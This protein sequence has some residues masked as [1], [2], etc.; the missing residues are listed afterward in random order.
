MF[1]SLTERFIK[2]PL[3]FLQKR[4]ICPPDEISGDTTRGTNVTRLDTS[5][6][7]PAH[8]DYN[9]QPQSVR[10]AYIRNAMKVAYIKMYKDERNDPKIRNDEGADTVRFKSSFKAKSGHKPV[11]FLPWDAGGAI[12]KLQIPQKGAMN[13]DPDIFFTAAINGCSIFVQGNAD[14]PSVYH[15]GGSTGQSDPSEGARFWRNALD[16]HIQNTATALARGPI[17]GEVS[18][19]DY[20]K[21]PGVA[22]GTTNRALQFE[23]HLQNNLNKHG[24]FTVTM[25]NPWGC[26]MGIRTGQD[27]SFYLQENGTIICNLVTRKGVQT[28]KYSRPMS[29]RKLYPGGWTNV[30]NM[31]Q[32]IPVKVIKY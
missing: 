26:V 20:I 3:G 1:D 5:G 10:Y 28:R 22:G 2:D 18:K 9:D 23:Q 24:K 17:Q 11:Y 12:I 14:S 6:F 21:E 16:N 19:T 29:V 25:V 15:A 8:T 31:S 13:P 30:A 4:A 32:Q 27:W 7:V